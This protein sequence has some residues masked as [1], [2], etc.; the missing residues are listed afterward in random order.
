MAA[1]EAD[2]GVVFRA[3]LAE[4]GAGEYRVVTVLTS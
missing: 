1:D 4:D 2:R 3:L